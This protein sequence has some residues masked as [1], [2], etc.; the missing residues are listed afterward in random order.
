MHVYGA[1]RTGSVPHASP[2]RGRGRGRVRRSDLVLVA[3]LAR[4]ISVSASVRG[5][6][7]L[8]AYTGLRRRQEDAG[9][10][11]RGRAGVDHLSGNEQ[12][13]WLECAARCEISRRIRGTDGGGIAGRT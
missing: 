6:R 10:A 9:R 1:A 7:I 13:A 8:Y 3:L 4:L 2:W 12:R 11:A 5:K